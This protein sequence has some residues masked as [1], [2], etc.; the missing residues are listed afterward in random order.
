MK[1][2]CLVAFATALSFVTSIANAEMASIYGGRDGL[3][4][5]RTANGERLNC[6]ALT[7]AHRKWRFGTL[8]GRACSPLVAR[9]SADTTPRFLPRSA[10][11][12]HA[13][14][15]LQYSAPPPSRHGTAPAAM[16]ALRL[17]VVLSLQGQA[18]GRISQGHDGFIAKI[19]L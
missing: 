1:S 3:C 6:A 13:R 19:A 12:W 18:G 17:T 2:V 11:R 9:A 5:S 16:L 15:S 10:C 4:G 7:A 14:T 8:S